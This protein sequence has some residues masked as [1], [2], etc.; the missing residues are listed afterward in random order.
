MTTEELRAALRVRE[1]DMKVDEAFEQ[2]IQTVESG[3]MVAAAAVTGACGGMLLLLLYV[4][5]TTG[6]LRF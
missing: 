1:S 2:V 4:T 6:F 3:I 5:F